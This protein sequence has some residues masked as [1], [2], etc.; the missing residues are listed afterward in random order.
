MLEH[1]GSAHTEIVTY[2]YCF[3]SDR[4]LS[5]WPFE[6]SWLDASAWVIE[7]YI[8]SQG[9]VTSALT[10]KAPN[11]P[12]SRR[13]NQQPKEAISSLTGETSSTLLRL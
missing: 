11:F 1:I 12:A 10:D 4:F 3:C 2:K 6:N 8:P 7:V 13:S 9:M 5:Y